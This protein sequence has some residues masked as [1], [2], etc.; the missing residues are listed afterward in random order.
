[1][2]PEYVE[3]APRGGGWYILLED[4]TLLEGGPYPSEE[5]AWAEI[6]RLEP[7]DESEHG[8]GSRARPTLPDRPR[9]RLGVDQC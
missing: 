5:A 6:A 3:K 9:A 7:I 2:H 8:R 4:G 1:M